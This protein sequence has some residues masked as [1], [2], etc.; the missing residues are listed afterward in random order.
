MLASDLDMNGPITRRK[1]PGF[2]CLIAGTPKTKNV[3]GMIDLY[4]GFC[5]SR[6]SS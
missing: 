4:N 3:S 1:Y 2:S 5:C 6:I